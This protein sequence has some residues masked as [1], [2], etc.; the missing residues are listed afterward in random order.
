MVFNKPL[1]ECHVQFQLE[2]QGVNS[3]GDFDQCVGLTHCD[4]LSEIKNKCD[5]SKAGEKKTYF[6]CYAGTKGYS[7]KGSQ[8]YGPQESGIE[9]WGDSKNE[10]LGKTLIFDANLLEGVLT[11]SE[12]EGAK[13]CQIDY[14]ELKQGVW[15]LFMSSSYEGEKSKI[16]QI[17]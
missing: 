2:V 7:G 8:T 6:G 11:I 9:D 5:F 15:H 10:P 13:L 4:N 14:D 12:K 16:S 3:S 17:K 1:S